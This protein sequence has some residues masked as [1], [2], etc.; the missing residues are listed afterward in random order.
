MLVVLQAVL[1]L[2]VGVDLGLD[3]GLGDRHL[4]GL[5]QLL[6]DLVASLD[7][8][9]EAPRLLDLLH[10]VGTQLVEGVELGGQLGEVVVE[11]RQL[12]LLDRLDGD[13]T[14]GRLALTGRRR[15]SG[16]LLGLASGHADEGLVD[17]LQHVVGA[18]L[19]GDAVDRVDLFTVDGCG[20]V[21]RDEVAVLG[22]PV[23]TLERAEPLTQGG[24]PLVHLRL[25]RL[26]G[27]DLDAE[28]GVVGQL[29]LR[30]DVHLG[31]ELQ[32]LP[33]LGGHL[34]HVDLGLAER[35][36]VV[37]V[38]GLAV[39]VGQRLVDRLLEHSAAAD[40]LVDDPRRHLPLR[41]PGTW[42]CW[43]MVLYAASRL[44]FSSSYDTSTVI[45]TRVGLTVS[46]AL[47]TTG[48][49][50]CR[51]AMCA[52]R[53]LGAGGLGAGG[54]DRSASAGPLARGRGAGDQGSMLAVHRHTPERVS[55]HPPDVAT[56]GAWPRHR[57]PRS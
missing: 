5:Q 20:Q 56:V 22:R 7:A 24:D 28:T 29:E 46:R 45:L 31:G 23:D 9:L 25:V 33:L 52:D 30:A 18:D 49:R 32:V 47:F 12:A 57:R 17:T 3:D 55:S 35:P 50:A 26:H 39:E 2:E 53:S 43:P 48:L 4:D 41:K 10:D 8:L 34:G 21:D 1:A 44:G 13:D 51:R 27:V 19:V 6:E 14:V 36:H 15:W 54:F 40:P 37:L 38:D 11:L 42:I 16:E